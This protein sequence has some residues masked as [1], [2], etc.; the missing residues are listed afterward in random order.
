MKIITVIL[1]NGRYKCFLENCESVA[2]Y[3]KERFEALGRLIEALEKCSDFS[4]IE[5]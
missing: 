3:G 1:E 2:G 5:V 4:N